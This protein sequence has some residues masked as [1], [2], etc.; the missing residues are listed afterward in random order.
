MLAQLVGDLLFLAGATYAL[1]ARSSHP[2]TLGWVFIALAGL[3]SVYATVSNAV[4]QVLRLINPQSGWRFRVLGETATG[5][6]LKTPGAEM[7]I[8]W[9]HVEAV[10]QLDDRHLLLVL[11]SPLPL[12]LRGVGLPLE[13]LRE[14]SEALVPELA[15]PPEKFGFVLHEQELGMTIAEAARVMSLRIEP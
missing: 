5:L 10:K 14:S 3:L 7:Q 2:S 4:L 1:V 15:P 8:G 11:P 6:R 9:R 12:E 13:E